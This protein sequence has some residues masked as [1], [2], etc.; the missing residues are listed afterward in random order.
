MQAAIKWYGELQCA[1]RDVVRWGSVHAM[2]GPVQTCAGC[3][4][5]Q[6]AAGVPGVAVRQEGCGQVGSSTQ[7]F[8][9]LMEPH[10]TDETSTLPPSYWL[11]VG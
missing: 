2:F 5:A 6:M 9:A 10:P 3:A 7:R 4:E 8:V 1:R 11:D